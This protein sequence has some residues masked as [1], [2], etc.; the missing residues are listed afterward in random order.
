MSGRFGT[1][2]I[3]GRYGREVT[4]DVARAVGGAVVDALGPWVAIARDTRPSGPALEAALVEGI[5]RAG[6]YAVPYGL[7]PTPALSVVVAEHAAF[8]AAVMLTASHNP[9]ADNGLKVLGPDGGKIG[10]RTRAAVEAGLGGVPAR[11]G[12]QA[13]ANHGGAR[14][15]LGWSVARHGHA[16][17]GLHLVV[18]A[19]NGAAATLAPA[20]LRAL[21]ARVDSLGGADGA[22]INDGCGALHP[23]AL[24]AAV[25]AAGAD[26]GVALDGDGDRLAL[27]TGDGRVLDGDALLWLL[28]EG[29][30]VVGTVMSNLGLE[31]GLAARGIRF[32]RTAVG[33]AE[34]AEGMAATGA[35]VGGE[36]SGHVLLA[37]GAPTADALDVAVRALAGG[38]LGPRLAGY[39]PSVQ[40]HRTLP[41]GEVGSLDRVPTLVADAEAEG[42]R[43][44]VRPSG[45]EPVVRVMVEHADSAR[46]AALVDGLVEALRG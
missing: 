38:P 22:R 8:D 2:G 9:A 39:T 29:E 31:R 19:A 32:V 3:R 4:E 35:R 6:G 26:A 14:S 42:A 40:H 12:G 13:R 24:V 46:G 23:A 5:V 33:D 43:V 34:V 27:V 16:L 41:R 17:A 11:P 1:D 21:G 25:R 18:D 28:A 45:T 36:P 44:V 10:A 7:L 30:V 37:G 15:Y 20:V